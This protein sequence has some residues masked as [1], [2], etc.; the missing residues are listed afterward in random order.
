VRALSLTMAAIFVLLQ[1]SPSRAEAASPFADWA[2]VFLAGDFH[3]DGGAPSEVFDN[4]RRDAA[5]AFRAVG[6]APQNMREF[7]V[8]PQRYPQQKPL[9]AEFPRLRDEVGR[10]A[11]QARGGCLVYLTSHG[12]PEGFQIGERIMRP[13]AL[14]GVLDA[15]GQRPTVVIISACFSGVFVPALARPNRMIMTAARP[16]RTSFGC[17][18]DERYPY[19]DGCVLETL[20]TAADFAQLATR[21]RTCVAARE[22]KEGLSPPSE[23]QVL[24]GGA[25][26]PMLPLYPF[27]P[28]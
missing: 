17:G 14:A 20:P 1:A 3:A 10:L 23:P 25:I 15:C 18:V 2:A 16:D 6:F 11:T 21:T 24:I 9:A 12:S 27:S 5:A 8:R 28:S 22:R 13:A 4:A 19:F 26:R 7:S